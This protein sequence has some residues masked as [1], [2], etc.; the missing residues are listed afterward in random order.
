VGTGRGPGHQ[1][2][3]AASVRALAGRLGTIV[4]VLTAASHHLWPMWYDSNTWFSGRNSF[5]WPMWHDR[6]STGSALVALLSGPAL[7][8]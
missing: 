3:A 8:T 2:K 5:S 6:S 1:P 7:C 4:Q